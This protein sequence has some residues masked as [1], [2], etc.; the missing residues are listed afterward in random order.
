MMRK[1]FCFLILFALVAIFGAGCAPYDEVG[2]GEV[3]V[4]RKGA[5]FRTEG[6]GVQPTALLPGTHKLAGITVKAAGFHIPTVPK[7]IQ[8]DT[9]EVVMSKMNNQR[10]KFDPWLLVQQNAQLAP[11]TFANFKSWEDVIER[12]F[13]DETMR[14]LGQLDVGIDLDAIGQQKIDTNDGEASEDTSE[15]A[16][17]WKIAQQ[18]RDATEESFRRSYPEFADNIFILAAG[19]GDVDFPEAILRAGEAA[20]AESYKTLQL[21]ESRKV[22]SLENAI[23]VA[24][25][26]NDVEAFAI[27]ANAMTDDVLR[28]LGSDIVES[29]VLDPKVNATLIV[30][31]DDQGHI[32]WFQAD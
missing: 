17:R 25:S 3:D 28:Y 8:L 20:V 23:R 30:P 14:I 5:T 9:L 12:L 21:K 32:T 26:E 6:G 27:E 11:S 29:M 15:L 31:L 7:R 13:R 24:E 10:V 4:V 16:D 18:I 1:N 2:L 22:K 19:F